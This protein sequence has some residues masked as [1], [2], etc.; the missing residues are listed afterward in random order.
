VFWVLST[1]DAIVT[2]CWMV[3]VTMISLCAAVQILT[4]LT[5]ASRNALQD[6]M[7]SKLQDFCKN[8]NQ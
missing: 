2:D 3:L 6:G 7:T 8:T 5:V 1:E 4:G